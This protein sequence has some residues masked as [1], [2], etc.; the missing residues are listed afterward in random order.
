MTI[1]VGFVLKGVGAQ[2]LGLLNR[3]MQFSSVAGL[4]F[5]GMILSITVAIA[6]AWFGWDMGPRRETGGGQFS[7]QRR[8]VAFVRLEA[9]LSLQDQGNGSLGPLRR[10]HSWRSGAVQFSTNSD[11]MLLGWRYGTLPLGLYD[12]SQQVFVL[13]FNQL[14]SPL[15]GVAVST[16]S[17]LRNDPRR[18]CQYCL[19]A[20]SVVALIGM[21]LSA[22]MTVVGPDLVV[23]LFGAKWKESGRI[24]L[25][26]GPSIGMLLLSSTHNWLHLSLGRADRAFVVNLSVLAV[27]FA[28]L[29]V[30]LPFGPVGV[31]LAYSASLYVLFAPGFWYAGKPIGLKLSSVVEVVWRYFASAVSAAAL[32]WYLMHGVATTSNVYQGLDVLSR[33][34]S[35]S[36]FCLGSY[37]AFAILFHGSAKPL[38]KITQTRTRTSSRAARP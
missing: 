34:M 8:R 23:L 6:M 35:V 9:G 14:T 7:E 37:V 15:A 18:Y 38:L 29:M 31:A 20:I 2:H 12:R 22:V 30:A 32:C 26:F 16:L 33:V 28:G 13:P 10:A 11:K 1:C 27:S 5:T 24:F 17:G 4:E 19:G 36:V 25:A 3:R 21:A